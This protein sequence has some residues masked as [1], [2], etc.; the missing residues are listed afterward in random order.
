MSL[1]LLLFGDTLSDIRL[2]PFIVGISD[3]KV[4]GVIAEISV[5]VEEYVEII[6]QLFD[7][8]VYFSACQSNGNTKVL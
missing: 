5:I 2:V 7:I 1:E 3:T 6:C 8:L 4:V